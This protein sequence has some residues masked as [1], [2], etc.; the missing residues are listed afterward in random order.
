[1]IIPDELLLQVVKPARYI[2]GETNM[3]KKN[4]EDVDIRF[5][6]CFPDV[7]E[8]GMSHIGLQ[9]LYYMINERDDAYCERVFTPW[10]DMEEVMR[11]ADYPLFA[12]ESL[13][14]VSGF[15][16]L[17]FTLQYEMSYTNI[18]NMLSLA[19]IPFYSKDREAGF[20][21]ICAGGPCAYNPEPLAD[22][23][24]FFYIGEG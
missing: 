9:I 12:L 1:M 21:I 4:P 17:G 20:P 22:I 8:V 23:M 14:P 3:V 19:G 18:I 7:Y 11:R 2:G 15:D 24:D 16:M 10:P 6:F 13:D 5:G